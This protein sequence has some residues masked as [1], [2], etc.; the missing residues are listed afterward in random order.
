MHMGETAIRFRR[1]TSLMVRGVKSLDMMVI[2]YGEMAIY[3][4]FVHTFCR[5]QWRWQ[6]AAANRSL[7][8]KKD[9]YQ[10]QRKAVCSV[11]Q[12]EEC[13]LLARRYD[14]I[15]TRTRCFLLSKE[16]IRAL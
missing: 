15:V 10:T 1:V 8:N 13:A 3:T 16:H 12:G 7:Q 9:S 6:H 11:R 2:F 5:W 4:L 14:E